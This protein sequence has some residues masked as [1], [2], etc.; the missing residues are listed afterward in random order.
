MKAGQPRAWLAAIYGPE[1]DVVEQVV[2]GFRG[3]GLKVT[4]VSPDRDCGKR[5][6][7]PLQLLPAL[8]RGEHLILA[9]VRAA[10]TEIANEL[11]RS[12]GAPAIFVLPYTIPA[13]F[14]PCE[15]I[16]YYWLQM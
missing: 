3:I 2:R 16:T 5:P 8:L 4:W 12:A 11:L 14:S 10:R 15:I 9:P 1:P 13:P 7:D 6:Q